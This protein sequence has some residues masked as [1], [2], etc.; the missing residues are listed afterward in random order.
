MKFSH[1]LHDLLARLPLFAAVDGHFV[2]L[3][4]LVDCLLDSGF[5]LG[6]THYYKSARNAN[7]LLLRDGRDVDRF[8]GLIRV[9][10]NNR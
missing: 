4:Y 5:D 2:D 7:C 9:A 6:V 10:I 3:Y 1:V 8:H